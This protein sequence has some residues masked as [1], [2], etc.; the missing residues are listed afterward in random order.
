MS[1]PDLNWISQLMNKLH[2]VQE[3]TIKVNLFG[4]EFETTNTKWASYQQFIKETKL[5]YAGTIGGEYTLCITETSLGNVYVV[6][7]SSGREYD[8][9]VYEV[10]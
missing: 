7:H 8:L 1:S 10:W 6:K 4:V 3:D 2:S 9:T 5:K